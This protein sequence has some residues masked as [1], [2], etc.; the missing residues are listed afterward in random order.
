MAHRKREGG[1]GGGG[2]EKGGEGIEWKEGKELSGGRR[3]RGEKEMFMNLSVSS[4][5][6][7]HVQLQDKR[8]PL[9]P[10]V[11][12]SYWPVDSCEWVVLSWRLAPHQTNTWMDISMKT[13]HVYAVCIIMP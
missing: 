3:G 11:Y 5:W 2:G 1:G 10:V 13:K 8:R 4:F 9:S 6:L 12:V 7:F